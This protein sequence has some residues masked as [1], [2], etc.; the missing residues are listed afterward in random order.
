[1]V[2]NTVKHIGEGKL[3]ES[4]S[5][6]L[7]LQ[8]KDGSVTTSKLA[9]D[10]VTTAKIADGAVTTDKIASRAITNAK[11][12]DASVSVRTF[13]SSVG[14][15]FTRIDNTLSTALQGVYI[16]TGEAAWELDKSGDKKVTVPVDPTPTESSLRP[17]SSGGVYT[18]LQSKGTYSKPS[19]G[20]PMTDLAEAVQNA[21]GTGSGG[22]EIIDANSYFS[23]ERFPTWEYNTDLCNAIIAAYKAGKQVILVVKYETNYAYIPVFF[24]YA[25]SVADSMKYYYYCTGSAIAVSSTSSGSIAQYPTEMIFFIAADGNGNVVTKIYSLSYYNYPQAE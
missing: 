20:I 21:I 8:I 22:F 18:A 3:S 6:I 4:P 13:D 12:A 5:K 9:D 2:D 7:S 11:L 19:G 15:E 14:Q 16:Q 23:S 24:P 1:M 25:P 10:A 17:V